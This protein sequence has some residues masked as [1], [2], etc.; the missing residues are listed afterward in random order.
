MIYYMRPV[1][2]LSPKST[3]IKSTY[4]QRKRKIRIVLNI[5]QIP[6]TFH[7]KSMS[8][9]QKYHQKNTN[10][11]FYNQQVLSFA[12]E[13]LVLVFFLIFFITI[14]MEQQPALIIHQTTKEKMLRGFY[15]I[16]MTSFTGIN[17]MK[18]EKENHDK[19][20]FTLLDNSGGNKDI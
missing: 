6:K 16:D 19:V 9:S 13:I 15:H 3:K 11:K 2:P 17:I 20:T 5:L 4:E 8:K 1:N 7:D 10:L 14:L 18:L 12:N